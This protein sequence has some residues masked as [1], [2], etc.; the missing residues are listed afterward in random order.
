M[1][2]AYSAPPTL[3]FEQFG[4]MAIP[5]AAPSTSIGINAKTIED[6][7]AVQV[8]IRSYQVS[9]FSVKKHAYELDIIMFNFVL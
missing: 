5:S 2:A 9:C 4:G 1:G 7:L 8:I 6:H 3:G